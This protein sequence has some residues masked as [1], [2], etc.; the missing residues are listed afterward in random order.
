MY[1]DGQGD[2][3]THPADIVALTGSTALTV[4][5]ALTFLVATVGVNLVADVI[6]PA[7]DLSKLAPQRISFRAGGYPTAAFS[8]SAVWL[9]ALASL[10]GFAWVIGALPAVAGQPA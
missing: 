5:A 10:S 9:D 3:A 2:P 1:Q 7:Y 4:V 8:F 6:P